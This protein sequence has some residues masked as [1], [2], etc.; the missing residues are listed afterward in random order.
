MS[1]KVNTGKALEL[2]VAELVKGSCFG[3]QRGAD[4]DKLEMDHW[5]PPNIL[6]GLGSIEKEKPVIAFVG[7][8]FLPAWSAIN[9]LKERELTEKIEVCGLGS[10]ALDIARFYDR[11]RVIGTMVNAGKLIRQGF[12]DVIVASTGCVPLD[13]L[14]E[15]KRVESKVIWVSPQPIGGLT[16]RTDDPIEEVVNDLISGLD[17]VWV[18]DI[19][20][21]GEIATRVA[22][23]LKRKGDCLLS[24]K[25]AK[26]GAKRCKEDCDLC[27]NAC[28]NSLLIG[29]AMRKVPKEGVSALDQVEKGCYFCGK[30]DTAC[31]ENIPIRDLI[32]ATLGM[33]APDEKFKMR[34][35]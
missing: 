11:V 8:N 13:I 27:F 14:G 12:A 31:P 22:Q 21:V 25:K 7:D 17:A 34:A 26:E 20:K 32:T 4:K 35:K 5:P 10:V 3:L 29:Q 19:D 2:Q 23:K 33:R 18:R 9:Y 1:R 30:C 15:A 6:G 16:D 28:P 24:E